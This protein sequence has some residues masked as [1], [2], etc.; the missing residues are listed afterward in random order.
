VSKEGVTWAQYLAMKTCLLVAEQSLERIERITGTGS[1]IH[2]I[3]KGAL[4]T[5][6]RNRKE[7]GLP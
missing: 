4:E 6:R 1:D 5:I 7:G 2:D 3:A